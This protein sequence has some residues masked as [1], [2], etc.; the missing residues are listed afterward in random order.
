MFTEGVTI[1]GRDIKGT[2]EEFDKGIKTLRKIHV[3]PLRIP[4]RWNISRIEADFRLYRSVN[5]GPE[6]LPRRLGIPSAR[7]EI[8]ET[9][10][11]KLKELYESY[12]P[13]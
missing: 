2:E 3:N 7:A 12:K 1:H 4:G 6:H 8:Y 9:I 13:P 5:V 11:T 10:K